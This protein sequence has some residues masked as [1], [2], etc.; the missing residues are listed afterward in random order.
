MKKATPK[1]KEVFEGV[2]RALKFYSRFREG[3][4]VPHAVQGYLLV[5]REH[6]SVA[7]YVENILP[8][9]EWNK[10]FGRSD[11]G[12]A[13]PKAMADSETRIVTMYLEGRNYHQI[14]TSNFAK[15]HGITGGQIT[16][17]LFG[18]K[19]RDGLV[20]TMVRQVL[21]DG[22]YCPFCSHISRP[23]SKAYV[24]K[25]TGSPCDCMSRL[26]EERGIK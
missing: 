11:W 3:V 1:Y 20:G 2:S 16:E 9:Y 8:S 24:P 7:N 18:S 22:S 6:N 26:L 15:E 21:K 10:A 5:L 12:S 25:M 19:R 14:W 23:N 13:E 17:W 4:F